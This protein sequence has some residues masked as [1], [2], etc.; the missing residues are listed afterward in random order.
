MVQPELLRGGSSKADLIQPLCT[1]SALHII[2]CSESLLITA[3]DIL[4]YRGLWHQILPWVPAWGFDPHTAY[5]MRAEPFR[6][7]ISWVFLCSVISM[8]SWSNPCRIL[9]FRKGFSLL[10]GENS[11]TIVWWKGFLL[12]LGENL[13]FPCIRGVIKSKICIWAGFFKISF[14]CIWVRNIS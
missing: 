7:C 1:H 3:W 10:L 11:F 9:V 13:G 6:S 8:P 2:I 4:L 12:L 14:N 5:C